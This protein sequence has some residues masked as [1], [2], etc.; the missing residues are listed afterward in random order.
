MTLGELIVRLR[1]DV[2]QFEPAIGRAA[3]SLGRLDAAGRKAAEG[4]SKPFAAVG[5]VM[6]VAAKQAMDFEQAFARVD[7]VFDRSSGSVDKLRQGILNLS[8]TIPVAATELSQMAEM[9]AQMGISGHDNLLKFTE[10]VARLGATADMTGQDAAMM[11]ARIAQVNHVPI[12]KIE[13][14]ASAVLAVSSKFNATTPEVLRMTMQMQGLGA[15]AG[16]S[17]TDMLGLAAAVSSSGIRIESGGTAIGRMARDIAQAT[18]EGGEKLEEFARIAGMSAEQFKQAWNTDAGSTFAQLFKGLASEG[19]NLFHTLDKLGWQNVRVGSTAGALSKAFEHVAKGMTEARAGMEQNIELQRQSEI[20]FAT[21]ASKLGTLIEKVRTLAIEFGT[22]FLPVIGLVVGAFSIVVDGL[23]V[24]VRTFNMLPEPIRSVVAAFALAK[25]AMMTFGL[26]LPAVFAVAMAHFVRFGMLV[27]A[28][29]TAMW[30]RL[31]SITVMGKA[32]IVAGVGLLAYGITTKLLETFDPNGTVINAAAGFFEKIRFLATNKSLGELA[33]EDLVDP[34][35]GLVIGAG[36]DEKRAA[37]KPPA[38]NGLPSDK[39]ALKQYQDMLRDVSSE[40]G[41]LGAK[42]S[43]TY[44][45]MMAEINAD[46]AKRVEQAK[47]IEGLKD[48]ALSGLIAKIQ[49]VGAAQREA[50]TQQFIADNLGAGLYQAQ[51]GADDL[52]KA[53]SLM[54]GIGGITHDQLLHMGEA[55]I[56]FGDAG[57]S[58]DPAL[59]PA[60]DRV[61]ELANAKQELD[62]FR[63]IMEETAHINGLLGPTIEQSTDKFL[64]LGASLEAHGG[65]QGLTNDQLERYIDGLN[66]IPD[67]VVGKIDD[68]NAALAEQARRYEALAAIDYEGSFSASSAL[69]QYEGNTYSEKIESASEAIAK[70]KAATTDW[71]VALRS[72]NELFELMGI[73]ADEGIGRVIGVF[74]SSMA[75]GQDLGKAF[76]GLNQVIDASSAIWGDDLDLFGT[77]MDNLDK[78]DWAGFVNGILQA[79]AAFMR[80]TDSASAFQRAVGGA[81]VGAQLGRAIGSIIPGGAIVGAAAGAIIGGIAGVFRS[82]RWAETGRDAGRVLGIEVGREM[83]E[84]IQETADSLNISIANASLLHLTDAISE[85][86]RAASEFGGPIQNLIQGIATGSIPAR[87]GLEQLRDVWGQLASEAQDNGGNASLAMVSMIQSMRALGMET[88]EMKDWVISNLESAAAAFDG[89]WSSASRSRKAVWEVNQRTGEVRRDKDGNKVQARGEDGKLKW[90]ESSSFTG[91]LEISTQELADSSAVIFG[92]TFSAMLQEKGLIGAVDAMKE[93]F[94][95]LKSIFA[96]GGFSDALLKPFEHFFALAD[97]EHFR[98]AAEGAVQLANA[99]KGIANAGYMTQDVFDALGTQAQAMYDQAYNA[100]IEKGLPAAEAQKAALQAIGPILAQLVI[101]GDRF[102]FTMGEG[103]GGLI[104]D[105]QTIGGIR[106]PTGE[107]DALTSSI[108]SLITAIRELNGLAVTFKPGIGN[109]EDIHNG[110]GGSPD[111]PPPPTY[112]HA[113]DEQHALGFYDPSMRKDKI[114]KVHQGEGVLVQPGGFGQG[115]INGNTSVQFAPNIQ[116]SYT[117]TDSAAPDAIAAGV[118]EAIRRNING[119]QT[120]IREAVN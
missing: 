22:N 120:T 58:I 77:I 115:E 7:R 11:M 64:E 95:Q 45:G 85:S 75:I 40:I 112:D 103:L 117:G 38:P 43:G 111:G 27:T 6:G 72:V 19:D 69:S 87:E 91:G 98:G 79:G 34:K 33:R 101:L 76:S 61:R 62:E 26:N 24:V 99:T 50:A 100:A 73:S 71:S 36:P 116:I 90:T 31:A 55:A 110:G 97:D 104:D 102:G 1:A 13:N 4:F 80:A 51:K 106:F 46:I 21:T 23:L 44:A 15:Q 65:L 25:V 94:G 48:P 88:Q 3:A 18:V 20:I 107:F 10:V 16:L 60:I 67:G 49:A 109:A 41:V 35:T 9:G 96:D 54:G 63:K 70:A 12:D 52:V 92:A 14:L 8:T 114:I 2:S 57:A 82:P 30:A 84:A 68:M 74:T 105:A 39:D 47:A 66:D 93:T 108:Y 113:P 28:G 83:A 118:E 59:Q 56:A 89:L 42:N 37:P 53:L 86:G 29:W 17:A 78:I 32:A 119:L 81:T 5:L